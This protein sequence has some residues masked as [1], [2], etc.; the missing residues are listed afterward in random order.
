MAK[1]ETTFRA[2]DGHKFDTEAEA[3]KHSE[4]IEAR[5][6][7]KDARRHYAKRLGSRRRRQT[8]IRSSCRCWETTGLCAMGM[9]WCGRT[10]SAYRSTSGTAT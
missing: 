3:D 1:Q 4:L 9:G 10:L 2:S 7:Y 8:G 6:A 5:L